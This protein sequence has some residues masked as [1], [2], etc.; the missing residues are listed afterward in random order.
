MFENGM[1]RVP[2]TDSHAIVAVH[3]AEGD[4]DIDEF[5]LFKNLARCLV[6]SVRHTCIGHACNGLG[7]GKCCALGTTKEAATFL[8]RLHQRELLDLNAAL[9][10]LTRVHVEA[11]GTVVDLRDPQID[12]I[13]ELARQTTL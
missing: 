7:P 11:I 12:K 4:G 3:K 9:E 13:D 2:K 1:R 8:P 6:S 10:E 5:L